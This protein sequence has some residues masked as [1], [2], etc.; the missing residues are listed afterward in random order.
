MSSDL[1]ASIHNTHF[2]LGDLWETSNW[3]M[4][5]SMLT[6]GN[7]GVPSSGVTRTFSLHLG[8]T[9]R[10]ALGGVP[11]IP[12]GVTSQTRE[13][14][15]TAI[16][17]IYIAIQHWLPTILNSRCRAIFDGTQRGSSIVAPT[18]FF[19]PH[20][21]SFKYFLLEHMFYFACL[22]MYQIS[23]QANWQHL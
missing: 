21:H 23:K 18:P 1:I 22:I 19:T 10:Q 14:I 4:V 11:N 6:L 2:Y 17:E 7:I 8:V 3:T 16:L 9:L 12:L 20:V 15:K 13:I 5:T